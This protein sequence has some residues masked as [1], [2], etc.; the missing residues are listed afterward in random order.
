MSAGP[1]AL[2]MHAHAF[3]FDFISP[4]SFLASRRWLDMPELANA[5]CQ[6]VVFGSVLAH[7]G[8]RGPGEVPSRRRNGLEDLLLLC[9]RDRIPLRG[10]PRHPFNS[11]YALR[12]VEAVAAPEPRRRLVHRYFTA[13]WTDGESLEDLDVLR[14]CLADVGIEQDPEDAASTP[15]VRRSL[16][17]ATRDFIQRGGFG[18]PTFRVGDIL[19]FGQDRMDLAA[20]YARG[21]IE[22]DATQLENMLARPQPS[23]LT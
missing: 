4:Y 7:Y 6:P 17:S 1:P 5:Q 13:A 2:A 9:A 23:R 3:Y 11:V 19:F 22:L 20:S 15:L 12:S 10:P 8:T 18:V 14:R 21:A 16:K